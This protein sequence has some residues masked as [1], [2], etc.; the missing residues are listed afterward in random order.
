MGGETFEF[1]GNVPNTGLMTNL[2]EG[3]CVE[4]PVIA[5]RKGLAPLYVGALPPQCA[6]LTGLTAQTEMLAVEGCLT[7]DAGLV[8]QAIAH[9]PLTASMLSL[10]EIRKLVLEMFRK[11]KRY[12][13]QFKQINI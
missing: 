8:Y 9:D 10:A 13:P 2:P 7:G 12:L 6:M 5:S 11:N 3:A 1:N 4:V